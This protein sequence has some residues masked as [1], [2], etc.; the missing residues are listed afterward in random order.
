MKTFADEFSPLSHKNSNLGFFSTIVRWFIEYAGTSKEKYQEFI[1]RKLDGI[2]VGLLKIRND[3]SYD[4]M[5]DKIK[6]MNY[7]QFMKLVDEVNVKSPVGDV[8]VQFTAKYKVVP[9]YSYE[10]LHEKYGGDKTGW[11]G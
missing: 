4:A 8:N 11:H 6:K 9:I 1:E 5:A 2:I 7:E 3:K 10:E